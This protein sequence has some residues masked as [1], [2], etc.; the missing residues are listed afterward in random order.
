MRI[1]ANSG[2]PP[3]KCYTFP[4]AHARNF[5][6]IIG[7]FPSQ[8]IP[9]SMKKCTLCSMLLLLTSFVSA[10]SVALDSTFGVNG[11]VQTDLLHG[12]TNTIVGINMS[13]LP[14]G[15]IIVGG[16]KLGDKFGVQLFDTNGAIDTSFTAPK[17][18]FAHF[19]IGTSIQQD[20]N[21]IICAPVKTQSYN[22]GVLRMDQ[23]GAVDSSFGTAGV[24][25]T[26]IRHVYFSNLFEQQDHKIIVFGCQDVPGS[27]D[28]VAVTRLNA[29]GS[30]DS[31]F[32]EN[33]RF[34]MDVDEGDEFLNAGLQQPD[35]KLLFTGMA[36]WRFLLVRL[37]LDGSLDSTFG[38][39]GIVVTS[40]TPSWADA[41]ALQP[42]GKIVI[43]GNE[44][45][46]N[47]GLLARYN[48]DGSLDA[49]FGDHGFHYFPETYE[50][51]AV[52][53]L[54]NGK[55]LGAL[56]AEVG[57]NV[58]V[59]LA[60]LLPD[61]Q[62]DSSFGNEG[63]FLP[64]VFLRSR[65]LELWGNKAFVGGQS[66]DYKIKIVRFLLDLNV[67]TINP[68]EPAD[69][70]L[71]MYPNPITGPFT[72]EFGLSQQAPVSIRLFDMNGKLVQTFIDHQPF[73]TGEYQ[74]PLS[75]P[76]QLAAG[77]YVLTLEVGEEKWMSVQVVKR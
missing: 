52:A 70:N 27:L 45:A 11:V 48:A 37:N 24:A 31:T 72:M 22:I 47:Q 58:G 53:I 21:I 29:D 43:I 54:P 71:W 65:T 39:N 8:Q 14:N 64:G 35:G 59:F 26:F 7:Y 32:A 30:L 13:V 34:V 77:N 62:R 40:S 66:P 68:T 33:G 9:F 73:E 56:K 69:N 5:A 49:S 67:G 2:I 57:S 55:I 36:G 51:V 4:E 25:S 60:Q 46:L 6:I 63:I 75:C 10:Q 16:G 20:G 38:S 41:M 12:S 28:P 17:P 23:S 18:S 76:E 15:K 50:G 19:Q 42:D 61:G 3:E 1:G 44:T 74:L